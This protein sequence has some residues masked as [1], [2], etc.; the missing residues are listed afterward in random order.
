MSNEHIQNGVGNGPVSNAIASGVNLQEF[1]TNA[2]LPK[3]AWEY[4]DSAIVRVARQELVGINDIRAIQ[5]GVIPFN[6][7]GASLFTMNRVDGL[8]P[9]VM[10]ET[11]DVRG[12]SDTLA[13]DTI[14]TPLPITVKDFPIN[15]KRAAMARRDGV[16]YES[17]ISDEALYQVMHKLEDHLFN[18]IYTAGGS[19]AYGYTTFPKRQEKTLTASWATAQ[20][21]EIFS[22][23]NAMV[24][25]SME[26]YHYGPWI[27]YIPWQYYSRLNEDYHIGAVDFPSGIIRNRL[28]EIPGLS[29]IKTSRFL[30]NDNV[31]LVEMTTRNVRLIDGITPTVVDW[32]MAASPNWTHNFKAMAMWVPFFITNLG[33]SGNEL[34]GIIHGHL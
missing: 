14:G 21:D 29:A 24:T 26:H 10:A 32:T 31:V 20:P 19:T 33:S 34:S 17:I 12:E 3:D 16:P 11:P 23:L 30:A 18:G 6:G 25:K 27:L 28:L 13:F 22:D 2:S 4:I 8:S 15:I 7:L 5:G 1:R 9:A